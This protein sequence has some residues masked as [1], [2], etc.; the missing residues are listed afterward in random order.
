MTAPQLG[1]F[2][3]E[4]QGAPAN[5]VNTGGG[6]FG[7]DGG[8]QF[9]DSFEQA[10]GQ[11]MGAANGT[12]SPQ[13]GMTLPSAMNALSGLDF[14]ELN[15]DLS[16]VSNG[17]SLPEGFLEDLQASLQDYFSQLGNLN[18]LNEQQLQQAMDDI[19]NQLVDLSAEYG[20]T[21]T[22]VN[23]QAWIQNLSS[24]MASSLAPEVQSM[25]A[26]SQGLTTAAQSTTH[27]DVGLDKQAGASIVG[28]GLGNSET[29]A[30]PLSA[31][32]L[33]SLQLLK[34]TVESQNLSSSSVLDGLKSMM[35][36]TAATSM[37]AS[38]DDITNMAAQTAPVQLYSQPQT[39]AVEEAE[40]SLQ[41]IPVPPNHRQF[42]QELGERIMVMTTK[43]IQTA[44]IQLTPPELGSLM[45]KINVESEQASITFSSPHS[46]V[47]EALE[48]QSFR[49]KDMLE[50]QGVDLV[51]VDVSDQQKDESHAEEA[52]ADANGKG[53]NP[54]EDAESFLES[55]DE[56]KSATASMRLV[57]YYA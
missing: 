7:S 27:L 49:L 50:E 33:D 36:S 17:G 38:L 14:S 11:L 3:S 48:Q 55:L 18:S 32:Q 37:S 31:Q 1:I 39:S 51:D 54:D 22:P 26:R 41:R 24:S 2:L 16:T 28:S 4:M 13:E 9:A 12:A 25:L 21:L 30:K 6:V 35:S 23:A 45:V 15:L 34:Q 42:S 20:I 19:A 8:A 53:G 40:V 46:G 52:L 43:N 47:R 56:Q 29:P 57:D 10:M 44:E 5:P